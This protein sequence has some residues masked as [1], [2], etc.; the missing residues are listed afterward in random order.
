MSAEEFR[1]LNA[2]VAKPD[3]KPKAKR[4]K[5]RKHMLGTAIQRECIRQFRSERGVPGAIFH[6]NASLDVGGVSIPLIMKLKADG[7]DGGVPDTWG[8]GVSRPSGIFIEFK[9][10]H[11]QLTPAQK[12]RFP[13]L[14]ALGE[15]IAIVR[16]LDEALAL[17]EKEN[18]LRGRAA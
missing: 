14:E 6:A 5:V 13:I 17:L 9:G 11:E 15:R 8:R 1:A 2:P 4:A 18:I 7:V 16:S 10:R 3:L 12:E